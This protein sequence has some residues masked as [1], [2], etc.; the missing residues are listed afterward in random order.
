MNNLNKN[1]CS[2]FLVILLMPILAKR[3]A[4]EEI[5]RVSLNSTALVNRDVIR[6]G[7]IADI[8]GCSDPLRVQLQEL[9]IELLTNQ[10]S[11]IE[12]NSD[13]VRIRILLA[14][15]D[16]SR[17]QIHG[18]RN[19][20]VAR[21]KQPSYQQ[22]MLNAIVD[23]MAE[24]FKISPQDVSV[25]FVA[26]IDTKRILG[27][28]G[29]LKFDLPVDGK[30]ALGR[31]TVRLGVYRDGEAVRFLDVTIDSRVILPTPVATKRISSG[32]VFSGENIR[33]DRKEYSR[34]SGSQL[35][36]ADLFGQRAARLINSETT[37]QA[38][39]IAGENN[40]SQSQVTAIKAR[41]PVVVIAQTGGLKVSLNQATALQAGKIGDIIHVRNESSQKIITCRVVGSGEVE[42]VF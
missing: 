27:D 15:I 20:Q 6:L 30:E 26:P 39:M 33:F 35:A 21:D 4:C 24:A 29:D 40:I 18:S 16:Q 28:A 42:V 9:D 13:Q 2:M 17:F 10:A 34:W 8:V 22:Q 11:S 37:I 14:G 19:V 36:A 5:A 25:S 31:K 1:L 38:T 32:E 7:D 3:S 12:I 23:S 41:D